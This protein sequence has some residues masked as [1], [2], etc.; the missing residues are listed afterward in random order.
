MEG[1]S[2]TPPSAAGGTWT[3]AV[4]HAFSEG[5]ALPIGGVVVGKGGVLYGTAAGGGASNAGTIYS[6]TPPSSPGGVW[7]E[8]VLHSFVGSDGYAPS[9]TLT[10]TRDG[11]LYGT[12]PA[13]GSEG[14]GVVFAIRP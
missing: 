7:T 13:G 8:T 11:V 5:S 3:Y 6:L 4:L 1:F 2:L 12:A 14:W 9:A 10:L